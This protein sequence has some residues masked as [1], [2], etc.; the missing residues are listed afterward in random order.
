[1]ELFID[2]LKQIQNTQHRAKTQ[3]VLHWVAK[4]FP[5]LQP[6]ISWNQP[7]FTDHGTF[8]IGFSV[9]KHHLAVAPERVGIERFSKEIT[10]SGYQHSKELIR[11]Q[12]DQTIDFILLEKIIQFNRMDKEHCSTFWRKENLSP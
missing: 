6:K 8:I 11:I 3:E 4:K 10:K 9:A 5:M 7:I 2:Y 12:W 1:M